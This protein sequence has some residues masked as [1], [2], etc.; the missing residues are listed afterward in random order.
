MVAGA[1][2]PFAAEQQ[3]AG[4]SVSNPLDAKKQRLEV[5]K[6]LEDVLEAWLTRIPSWR[7]GQRDV[8][9]SSSE[10]PVERVEKKG[11]RSRSRRRPSPVPVVAR[12]SN[13]DLGPGV[14]KPLPALENISR[15]R[16]KSRSRSRSKVRK[17]EKEKDRDRDGEKKKSK[18][19]KKEDKDRDRDRDRAREAAEGGAAGGAADVASAPQ[20]KAADGGVPDWLQDLVPTGGPPAPGAVATGV[21]LVQP[22]QPHREVVVPQQFV[23]R[24]IGRGGEAIMGICHATGADVRIRQETKDLGYSLAIITGLPQAMD[25]AEAMISQK[26]GNVTEKVM[27]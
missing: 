6:R 14:P 15:S 23:S 4:T 27:R 16:S 25:A 7:C 3:D 2:W 12:R 18:K 9:R 21:G 10:L 19:E 1:Q 22:R 5:Q 26:L 8:G 17:K 13:F 24:L 20:A 11:T